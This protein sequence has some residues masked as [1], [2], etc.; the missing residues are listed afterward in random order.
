MPSF[1]CDGKKKGRKEK[2]SE[3]Q[4]NKKS[5]E[6][7]T[8]GK[9]GGSGEVQRGSARHTNPYLK[10]WRLIQLPQQSQ[11][12]GNDGLWEGERRQEAMIQCPGTRWDLNPALGVQR[13]THLN[14]HTHANTKLHHIYAAPPPTHTHTSC[15]SGS[16]ILVRTLMQIHTVH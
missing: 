7:Q 5:L 4:D 16:H 9:R 3:K 10:R 14:M 2:E 11:H 8:G 12:F 15:V 13:Q 6:K 1:C